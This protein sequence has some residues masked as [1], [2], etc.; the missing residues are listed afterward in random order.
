[1]PNTMPIS[2]HHKDPVLDTLARGV[3]TLFPR[4]VRCGWLIE[5][6][7]EAD[8]QILKNRVVHRDGC[9][10]ERPRTP[11]AGTVSIQEARS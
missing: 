10:R 3:Y 6:F 2:A 1:M 11:A 7:E 9:P 8:V 5:R 4:C